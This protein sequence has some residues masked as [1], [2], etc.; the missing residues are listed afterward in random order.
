MTEAE[1][2]KLLLRIDRLPAQPWV[3]PGC[4]VLSRGGV[5][6]QQRSEVDGWVNS[7]RGV[8]LPTPSEWLHDHAPPMGALAIL[9]REVHV[10]DPLVYE[11]PA[12]EVLG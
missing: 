12:S 6:E 11:M 8:I 9:G 2:R 5:P 7:K 10:D 3:R 4:V 1:I